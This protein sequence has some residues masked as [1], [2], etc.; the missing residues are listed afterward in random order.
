MEFKDKLL[1][2]RKQHGF[3]QTQLGNLVGVSLRSIQNY[4]LGVRY[5]KRAVLDKLCEVFNVPIDYM[6]TTD[7]TAMLKDY[8]DPS[9]SGK[10]AAQIFLDNANIL[11]SG[12]RISEEDKDDVMI[13]LQK[14]YWLSKENNKY[15]QETNKKKTENQDENG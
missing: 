1:K 13:A 10:M 14:I 3:T 4:E 8:G 15:A 9:Q 6:I 2:L 12:G 7:G 5:P 11:F